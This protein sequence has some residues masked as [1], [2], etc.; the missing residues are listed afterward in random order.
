ME[1]KSE[2]IYQEEQQ[3]LDH[4]KSFLKKFK[5]EDNETFLMLQ[6]M[7][8]SYEQLLDNTILITS[9]SDRFQEKYKM[10]NDQLKVQA[11]WINKINLQLDADNRALKLDLKRLSLESAF[12]QLIDYDTFQLSYPDKRACYEYLAK[13][14]WNDG[15]T[16][17]KCGNDKSCDGHSLLSKRCTKCRYDESP[18]AYTL[19]HKCKFDITKAFYISILIH[20]QYGD[21]SSYELSRMLQLRQKTCWNFKQK[22]TLAMKKLKL[23]RIRSADTWNQMILQEV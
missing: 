17:S 5:N 9:I 12:S 4:V 2:H 6:A 20:S 18:T 19:F 3:K 7:A 14:K 23:S 22:I 16:C 13:L 11:E 15:Y 10:V 21:I 1:E 8:E